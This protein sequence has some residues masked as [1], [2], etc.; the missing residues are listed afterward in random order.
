[1]RRAAGWAARAAAWSILAAGAAPA[2]EN[3]RPPSEA[4]LK[5]I[6]A[7]APAEA[8]ARPASA[9]KVLVWGRATSHLPTPFASA[10]LEI[11]GRKSR[12]YEAVTSEDPAAF[13]P[14]ALRSFDAIVMNNVHER[15]P[16]LPRDLGQRPKEEQDRLRARVREIQQSILEFVR[17][18]KGIAGI[19]AATAAFQT[20]AEYGQMMGGYYGG[21][22]LQ[23]VALKVEEPGH[24][25]LAMF[26]AK[27]FTLKDEIYFFVKEP[28]TR[29]DRRVLLSLDVEKMGDPGKRPDKDYAVTW[30]REFGRGRV[31]Y[32]SLGH[33]PAVYGNPTVL[34][35]YLAGLQFVLGDLKAEAAPRG[36]AS[37]E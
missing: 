10:A 17:G 6:E 22:I 18:G 26:D 34:K 30:V 25:L 1:M 8:P 19:H 16:F 28:Y 2:A 33:E 13:L 7:A 24:P 3:V 12:A 9:R 11:V 35:H 4:E 23:D 21:H 14:D 20:W 5:Q 31:F 32:C 27:G 15:E 36:E 29:A 37:K